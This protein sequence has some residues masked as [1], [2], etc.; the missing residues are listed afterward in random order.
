[1]NTR[2]PLGKL[3]QAGRA[4][5][6][7]RHYSKA[8]ILEAYFNLAPYGGNVEGIGTASR[9]YFDKPAGALDLGE[10]LALAVVPQN[11]TARFPGRAAGRASLLEARGR[12]LGSLAEFRATPGPRRRGP[13]RARS[14]V[15]AAVRTAFPGAPLRPRPCR[16]H[17]R[18]GGSHHARSRP[19]GAAREPHRKPPG[20]AACRRDHQ[21]HRHAGGPSKHGGAGAGRVGGLLRF[22]H[23]RPGQRRA[24]PRARPDPRSSRCCTGWPSTAA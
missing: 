19:A 6:L 8:E 4:I 14:G 11:P 24:R 22:R 13:R 23:R 1:M 12:L 20:A 3:A 5:Q 10:S 7:E 9:V 15:P 21:C 18:V 16:A 17:R 2:T